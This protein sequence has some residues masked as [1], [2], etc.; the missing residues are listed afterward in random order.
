MI[1]TAILRGPGVDSP[2]LERRYLQNCPARVNWKL[3]QED[4]G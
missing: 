1:T 3:N 4:D 2:V